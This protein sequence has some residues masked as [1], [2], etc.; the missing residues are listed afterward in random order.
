ML[1]VPGITLQVAQE[2]SSIRSSMILIVTSG[3]MSY[4]LLRSFWG[5]AAVMLAAVPLSI[6]K[7]ALRV[8]TL[9]ML[10]AYVDPDFLTGRLHHHGGPL[11]LAVSL[12][13]MLLLI[14]FVA[15]AESWGQ[16]SIHGEAACPR[17]AV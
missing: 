6:A 11:F 13:G 10:G 8:F 14:W 3:V 15:R 12:A 2:C 16:S 4:L 7:N 9:A 17:T 5:R 1:R